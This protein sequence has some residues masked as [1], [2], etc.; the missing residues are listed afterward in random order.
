MTISILSPLVVVPFQAAFIIG[1]PLFSTIVPP[2]TPAPVAVIGRVLGA[3]DA[4]QDFEAFTVI[5]IWFP[6]PEHSPLQPVN[7]ESVSA[8]AVR[9]MSLDVLGL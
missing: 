3:K 5:V 8:V 9:V 4:V 7:M 1:L 2:L 6:V